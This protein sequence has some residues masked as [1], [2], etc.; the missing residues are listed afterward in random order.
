M[1]QPLTKRDKLQ[2]ILDDVEPGWLIVEPSSKDPDDIE[3]RC[4]ILNHLTHKS[5]EISVDP[6]W[7][8]DDQNLVEV[9]NLV[10]Y[11]ISNQ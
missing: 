2:K 1:I 11:A 5:I 6:K 3:S 7:F 9:K 8:E 4:I 10:Q